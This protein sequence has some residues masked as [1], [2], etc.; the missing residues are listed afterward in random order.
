MFTSGILKRPCL[1]AFNSLLIFLSKLYAK[2]KK[3]L[4]FFVIDY[5]DIMNRFLQ[6]HLIKSASPER[7]KTQTLASFGLIPEG[8]FVVSKL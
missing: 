8:G 5:F 7:M 1:H 3:S 4:V 2:Q 6:N